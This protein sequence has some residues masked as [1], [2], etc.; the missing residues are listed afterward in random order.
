MKLVQFPVTVDSGTNTITL[1]DDPALFTSMFFDSAALTIQAAYSGT[2]DLGELPGDTVPGWDADSETW[3]QMNAFRTELTK[4]EF[5]LSFTPAEYR[6]IGNAT[7]TDDVLF[8]FWEA[9][10]IADFIELSDPDTVS[11]MAY[12]L[13]LGLLTQERHDEIMKGV[14]TWNG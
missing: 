2:L 8:Q 13:S 6:A 11:G 9:G 12:V 4:K 5:Q 14:S 3:R 7:A 10:K 1:P